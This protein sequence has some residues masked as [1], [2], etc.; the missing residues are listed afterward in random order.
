MNPAP[1]RE[2]AYY[3][4]A[5]G[6]RAGR[7]FAR[8]YSARRAPDRAELAPAARELRDPV[9]RAA[10]LSLIADARRPAPGNA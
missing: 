4:L 8:D 3:T 10:A 9:E 6:T 5:T 1:A 2:I 7:A